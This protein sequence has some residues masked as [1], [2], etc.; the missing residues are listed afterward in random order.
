MDFHLYHN[1]PLFV[2]LPKWNSSIKEAEQNK[3]AI[4]CDIQFFIYKQQ[5]NNI[6]LSIG[7]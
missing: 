3:Q 2:T 4:S 5:N 7:S 1:C 6:D